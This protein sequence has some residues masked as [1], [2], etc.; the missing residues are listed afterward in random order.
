MSSRR[1]RVALY[2]VTSALVLVLAVI[3]T[4]AWRGVSENR[5][6]EAKADRLL[7]VAEETGDQKPDRDQVVRLLGTDGGAVCA[8]PTAALSRAGYLAQMSNG[9]GGPGARPVVT[10]S[11]LVGAGLA[12]IAIYCPD[13]LSEF[14]EF[15]DD[16]RTADLVGE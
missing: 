5:E 16:L 4:V 14:K 7:A 9:A 10:D 1:Q 13:H 6:A 8:D 3:A 15:A 12:I 2:G 11:E